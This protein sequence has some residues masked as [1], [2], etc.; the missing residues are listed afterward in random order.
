MGS[1]LLMKKDLL[2]NQQINATTHNHMNTVT[3][4][5]ENH[6]LTSTMWSSHLFFIFF[7][8]LFLLHRLTRSTSMEVP[9]PLLPL[10]AKVLPLSR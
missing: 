10:L 1:H 3:S 9:L 2:S 8:Q 7:L 5:I 6:N 4:R